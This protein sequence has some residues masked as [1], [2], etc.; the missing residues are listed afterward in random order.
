MPATIKDIAKDTGLSVNTVSHILAGKRSH[1]FRES[2]QKKVRE[3]AERLEYSPNYLA[4]AMRSGR[5]NAIGLILSAHG[6]SSM[7][8]EKRLNPILS[9]CHDYKQHVVICQLGDLKLTDSQSL[10]LAARQLMVDGF[11]NN[12][13]TALPDQL[14]DVLQR[15][16]QPIVSINLKMEQDCIYPDDHFGAY[17]GT[18]ELIKQGHRKIAYV[19]MIHHRKT[20]TKHYSAI[21]RRN[22]YAAA[23]ASAGL[24]PLWLTDDFVGLDEERL[25]YTI[26]KLRNPQKRPS[27]FFC[28]NELLIGPIM[29][30]LV[31]HGVSLEGKKSPLMTFAAGNATHLG[32]AV[33][34]VDIPE[35]KMGELAVEFLAKKI[36]D[37]EY[38]FSSV[39]VRPEV[40][41]N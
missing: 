20:K 2:T 11:I 21:D 18:L 30:A 26:E 19:D 3:A 5:F 17:E 1:L 32:C 22:G 14:L 31:H 35:R 25:T 9:K 29:L 34:I 33:S 4:Q 12:F 36:E 8:T 38:S 24:E 16:N 15:R 37:N 28:Y 27:A 23:M 7:L 40:R 6:S 39:A 13:N 10:P 41:V